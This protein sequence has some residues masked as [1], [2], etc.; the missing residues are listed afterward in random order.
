MKEKALKEQ[1][2]FNERHGVKKILK[3]RKSTFVQQHPEDEADEEKEE[4]EEE[5][6]NEIPP[7]PKKRKISSSSTFESGSDETNAKQMKTP[8]K[9]KSPTKLNSPKP[10]AVPVVQ[11]PKKVIEAQSLNTVDEEREKNKKE[12]KKSK[13]KKKLNSESSEHNDKSESDAGHSSSSTSSNK[14]S[15]KEKKSKTIEPPDEKPP[16]ELFQ[17]F[18]KYVHT[19]KP[20]KAQK[21]F[22]K[23]PKKERKQLK[24]EYN[25][26][27]QI[28]LDRLKDYLASLSQGEAIAY[29]SNY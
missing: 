28:Y 21:A 13:K 20:H 2:E 23:L 11:S 18:V 25:E 14:N 16:S 3:R 6:E 29:V 12:K 15:K 24:A 1:N 4:D 22:D 17:Y 27:V 5:Q 10:N 26:K 8:T 19:G 9:Q 7:T